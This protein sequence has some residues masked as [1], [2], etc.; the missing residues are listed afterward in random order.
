MKVS[1]LSEHI[2]AQI[3]RELPSNN[4]DGGLLSGRIHLL[5]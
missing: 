2:I 3:V 5:Q 1:T 4:P